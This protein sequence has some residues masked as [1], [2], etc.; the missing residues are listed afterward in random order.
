V[1]LERADGQAL[2]PTDSATVAALAPKLTAQHIT[3]V[4][5]LDVGPPSAN[6][7]SWPSAPI[8]TS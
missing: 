3:N 7:S 8:T 4:L 2:T 5:T 6:S 1:V